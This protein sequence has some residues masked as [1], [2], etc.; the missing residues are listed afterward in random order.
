[1]LKNARGGDLRL[2]P[3]TCGGI[4]RDA[5]YPIDMRKSLTSSS[6]PAGL[7]SR[8]LLATAALVL[9]TAVPADAAFT[10][11][12]NFTPTTTVQQRQAFIDAKTYWE[13]MI[14]GYST[15]GSLSG[16][17]INADVSFIDGVGGILG[18]AGPDAEQTQGGITYTTQGSMQFDSA[19]AVEMIAT[20]S[21]GDVVRHEMGHILGIGTHWSDNGL[22]AG[23][24]GAQRFQ[25]TG[26]NALNAWRIEFNQAASTFVPVETTGGGGTAGAHWAE[27][28]GGTGP[29]GIVSRFAGADF[30]Y[31]MMTG[32]AN[33]PVFTSNVT[34]GSL[35]D[36]GYTI[37]GP[38]ATNGVYNF[39]GAFF[40]TPATGPNDYNL[41]RSGKF[42]MMIWGKLTGANSVSLSN[43]DSVTAVALM[44]AN[45]YTGGTTVSA[46]TLITGNAAALGS[47]G[48]LVNGGILDIGGFN[49]T[50]ISGLTLS[51]GTIVSTTG[52]ITAPV[53]DLRAGEVRAGLAGS[54]PVTKTTSGFVTLSGLNTYTGGTA[55]NGGGLI[56]THARA[57]S[58]GPVDISNGAALYVGAN[59]VNVGTVTLNEGFIA[60]MGG[61]LSASAFSLKSGFVTAVLSGG[62]ALAKSTAG[63]VTLSGANTY[64]GGTFVTG[65]TLALANASALGS[66]S[67]TISGG[68][69]DVGSTSVVSA[70]S[71]ILDTGA[72]AGT[73]GSVS[74]SSFIVR[75]GTVSATLAGSG[76]MT[77]DTG[78][79]VTLSA[80]NTFTGGVTVNA[81]TLVGAAANALGAGEVSVAGGTVRLADSLAAAR[82]TLSLD[83]GALSFGTLTAA[84]I[85]ALNGTS[86]LS[87]ANDGSAALALTAGGNN[88]S[89]AYSGILSGAGSLIKAGTGELTLSGVNSYTGGTTV[90]AGKLTLGNANAIGTGG[91]LVNGGTLNLGAVTLVTGAMVL[92]GGAITGT[93]GALHS[94]AYDLRSGSVGVILTGG[95]VTKSGAGELTLSSVNTYTGGTTVTAGKLI[96]ANSGAISNGAITV[97]GGTL[98]IG[99]NTL[100]GMGALTV[101]GGAVTGTTG[102]I[103]ASSFTL[104]SGELTARIQ[105][106]GALVK[107][108][109]GTAVLGASN[110]FSGGVNVAEGKLVLTNSGALG[111]GIVT[112]AN[113]ATLRAGDNTG[114]GALWTGNEIKL[115]GGTLELALSSTTSVARL[116]SGSGGVT[117]SGSGTVTLANA[118][119]TG[120]TT[121]NAGT[122][123]LPVSQLATLP[124]ALVTNGSGT[125]AIAGSGTTVDFT[126]SVTGDGALAFTGTGTTRLANGS[127]LT[128][129]GALTVGSGQTLSLGKASG[130]SAALMASLLDIRSGATLRGSGN[131]A[132]SLANAGTL[133]PGFSPGTITLGGDFT[134]TGT[135]TMETDATTGAHD[136]IRYAGQALLGGTLNLVYLSGTPAKGTIVDLLV[137]TNTADGRP[138]IVGNFSSVILPTGGG[139]VFNNGSGLDFLVGGTLF[140]I[141]G[142]KISPRLM[143]L[144]QAI[145]SASNPAIANA[146]NPVTIPVSSLAGAL[147]SAS[148]LALSSAVA[149]P[150]TEA[151]RE[152]DELR[153]HLDGRR[154]ERHGSAELGWSP[155]LSGNGSTV[156]STAGADNAAFDYR[157]FGGVVGIDKG[158]GGELTL[159][160]QVSYDSGRASFHDGGGKLDQDHARVTVYGSKLIA[161][162]FYVDTGAFGGVSL[163]DT[164]RNTVLGAETGDTTGWDA[165]LFVNTGFVAPITSAFSLTPHAGLTY[166]HATVGGYDESGSAL[167]LR[168]TAMN[169]DSLAARVGSGINARTSIADM[170]VRLGFD[171][172]F[173]RELLDNETDIGASF[174]SSPGSNFTTTAVVMPKD[175]LEVGPELELEVARGQS[176]TAAYRYEYAFGDGTGHRVDVGYRTRF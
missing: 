67:T 56:A 21:F 7:V 61:T 60:D 8:K 87:L 77:K 170:P 91:L 53:Y 26:A 101:S 130:E 159:G 113:G 86:D 76:A 116:L 45:D 4:L 145:A 132:G 97:T 142:A 70:G 39:N 174:G 155:Y 167:A 57:L 143:P 104:Q 55:I 38:T 125:L 20:N 121:V 34:V 135:L 13:S 71:L 54:A 12:L 150:V 3:G 44:A 16:L 173:V 146:L 10:I 59:L 25:Y 109:A 118:Q 40:M 6:N 168:V 94:A 157:T 162:K 156:T 22:L 99:A 14:T 1:M 138:S 126:R 171:V 163:Y 95:A 165:G 128:Q 158:V 29:T 15:T 69:L 129:T 152:T 24:T 74:A 103:S 176:V 127:T 88:A 136:Q 75:S 110:G 82:A 141:P 62:G 65:G 102:A 23:N 90:S 107:T 5:S 105:G 19:D 47:G 96:V 123:V 100:T 78:G 31:E 106:S 160:A 175:R 52:T 46:G 147:Q 92:D 83:G 169:H 41:G 108:T 131:I 151:M 144:T 137:D 36:M 153:R 114:F 84:N 35:V 33:S 149:L 120:A 85:G 72:I 28:P 64:S 166:T 58:T 79:T 49:I 48:V 50:G 148:P 68:T 111:S 81:G 9:A 133:S 140:D 30:E 17:A 98:D 164:R 32:W 73:S 172:S 66:G 124:G 2:Y 43:V 93:T 134:N 161:G 18:Q 11:T 80:G 122:L 63:T 117:Q 139:I 112:V 42:G 37:A 119:Y 51:G 89:T 154:F 27:I 115:A